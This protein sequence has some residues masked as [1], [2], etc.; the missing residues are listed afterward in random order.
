[1]FLLKDDRLSPTRRTVRCNV[2]ACSL[3][4]RLQ[5]WHPEGVA[6]AIACRGE[7]PQLSAHR[8]SMGPAAVATFTGLELW[9]LQGATDQ[10]YYAFIKVNPLAGYA[11]IA[12]AAG[13][14]VS[15]TYAK[16]V[17][18]RTVQRALSFLRAVGRRR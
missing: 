9:R 13:D 3:P 17:A 1:M 16:L 6:S 15:A 8:P 5:V 2:V 11:E 12:G 18:E 4:Q 7:P 10:Q 14:A